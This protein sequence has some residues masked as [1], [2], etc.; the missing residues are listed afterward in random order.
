MRNASDKDVRFRSA[1]TT[2]ARGRVP[3]PKDAHP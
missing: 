1:V 3:P 2:T